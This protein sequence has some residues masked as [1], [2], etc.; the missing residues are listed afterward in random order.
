M[1]GHHGDAETPLELE[2]VHILHVERE[3]AAKD[4]YSG[5]AEMPSYPKELDCRIGPAR[6]SDFMA[7]NTHYYRVTLGSIPAAS[8]PGA[9]AAKASGQSSRR[10]SI[11]Y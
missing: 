5:Y 7:G 4:E 2:P 10:R 8:P 1:G 11:R 6:I 9:P 3:D